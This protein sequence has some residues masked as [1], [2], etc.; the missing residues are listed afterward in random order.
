M[1]DVRSIDGTRVKLKLK[2]KIEHC[3]AAIGR[4]MAH[5]CCESLLSKAVTSINAN[6][7]I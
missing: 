2:K 6:E 3:C 7:E 4:K 1:N 5:F